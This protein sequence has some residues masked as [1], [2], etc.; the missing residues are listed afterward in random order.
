VRGM[1][2]FDLVESKLH[3]EFQLRINSVCSSVGPMFPELGGISLRIRMKRLRRAL[4]EYDYR[5][6]RIDIDPSKFEPDPYNLLPSVLSHET[7]HALQHIDR[8]IPYGERSCDLYTL[9]RLPDEMFPRT[10]DFYVKVPQKI[11]S[12]RPDLIRITAKEALDNRSKGVRNYIV[13]F[14]NKLRRISTTGLNS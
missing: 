8:T 14:E 1:L 12:L 2:E 5:S 7:M 3:L 9:A 13:W 4:A 11:L 10:R 6:L